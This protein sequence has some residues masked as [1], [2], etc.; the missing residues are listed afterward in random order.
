MML[1]INR[2]VAE[3]VVVSDDVMV[4]VSLIGEDIVTFSLARVNC[5][6]LGII[7]ARLMQFV[8]ITPEVGTA[9]LRIDSD[10]VRI[11][12]NAP[13]RCLVGRAEAR[14]SRRRLN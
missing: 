9:A 10:E 14:A 3:S 2:R 1:V 4:S 8:E 13:A 11:R 7:S 5:E 6:F 12:S